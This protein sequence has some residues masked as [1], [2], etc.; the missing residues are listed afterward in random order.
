MEWWLNL[1]TVLGWVAS[2]IF[3]LSFTRLGRASD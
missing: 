1:C 3:A 2:T